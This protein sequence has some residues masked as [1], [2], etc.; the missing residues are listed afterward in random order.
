MSRLTQENTTEFSPAGPHP[1][2][3]EFPL[4]SQYLRNNGQDL[5]VAVE[6][7][8]KRGIPVRILDIVD[9]LLERGLR[10]DPTEFLLAKRAERATT[11][12]ALREVFDYKDGDV[13][14]PTRTALKAIRK[15]MFTSERDARSDQLLAIGEH[16]AQI[17]PTTTQWIVE[18][19][20]SALGLNP[21][22][23]GGDHV[24]LLNRDEN[25]TIYGLQDPRRANVQYEDIAPDDL[26][27]RF[28]TYHTDSISVR[29]RGQYVVQE[30]DEKFACTATYPAG[31]KAKILAFAC[32][33]AQADLD[34]LKRLECAR[35]DLAAEFDLLD[36]DMAALS[37]AVFETQQRFP[38]TRIEY[39]NPMIQEFLPGG[40]SEKPSALP[41]GLAPELAPTFFAQ[42]RTPQGS[43]IRMFGGDVRDGDM[44]RRLAGDEGYDRAEATGLFDY[45]RIEP[46][47]PMY[48]GAILSNMMAS[49]NDNGDALFAVMS[50]YHN[51]VQ[52][53]GVVGWWR[54]NPHTFD[55]VVTYVEDAC[56]GAF[57]RGK[58]SL[59]LLGNHSYIL[60]KVSK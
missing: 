48:A 8:S 31:S 22:H 33:A 49:L 32:G 38:G 20:H 51:I 13:E 46:A 10:R 39:A 1:Q 42:L 36:M 43:R 6:T 23:N 52:I 21:V 7:L 54:I 50:T 57:E 5:N 9:A 28:W 53:L 40:V 58:A 37:L 3:G 15:R 14:A 45:T 2:L 16:V 55:E 27:R 12:T 4:T 59:G 25:G 26:G 11:E 35:P 24:A 30:N 44:V 56:P 18:N 41:A 34:S 29:M 60:C 47:H 19:A 17:S